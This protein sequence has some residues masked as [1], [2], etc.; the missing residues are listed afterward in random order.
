MSSIGDLR[1]VSLQTGSSEGRCIAGRVVHLTG[2]SAV[3]AISPAA[4]E[5]VDKMLFVRYPKS[6]WLPASPVDGV[7]PTCLQLWRRS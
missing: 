3:L 2:E 6:V 7:L 4:A 5:V 1:Y